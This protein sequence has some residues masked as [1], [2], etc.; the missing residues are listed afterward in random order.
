MGSFL[1]GFLLGAVIV[2]FLW[3]WKFG[4]PQVTWSR[5]KNWKANF[6]NNRK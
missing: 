1:F 5:F 6:I 2:D 4:I 3:A